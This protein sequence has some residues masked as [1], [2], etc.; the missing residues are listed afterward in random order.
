MGLSPPC[1][2]CLKASMTV[3]WDCLAFTLAFDSSPIKG[4]GDM[5]GLSCCRPR[6]L[7][8]GLRVKSAM[9]G[10]AALVLLSRFSFGLEP[11]RR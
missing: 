6:H 2:Y 1:G 10:R 9:T 8:S 11:V 3:R 5:V 7:T 4:E